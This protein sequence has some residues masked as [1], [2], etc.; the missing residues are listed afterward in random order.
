MAK[1]LCLVQ[2]PVGTRSG[3]GDHAR[4]IV[5]SLIK[6]DRY[7]VKIIPTRWG[8]TPMNALS[9]EDP[10]H[11]DI[12]DRILTE[13][14]HTQPDLFIQITVP[15]E[16][17]PI[18]KFNIGITAGIETTVPPHTWLEGSNRMNLIIVPSEFS[19]TTL[20]HAVYTK[21]DTRTKQP[22]GN[23]A[24]EKPI[25][26][27]FEGTDV[28]V[29]GNTNAQS[30]VLD[31]AMNV[32]TTPFN[33]LFVGHWL[34]GDF[35]ED[36]KN[37]GKLIT[38]FYTVF[39]NY[40]K[41]TQP[42]LILKTSQATF[43]VLDRERI[44][45]KI[46]DVQ[47]RFKGDVPPIYFI[48]GDLTKDEMASLYNHDKVHAHISFTKGEGF[49][50]PLLEASLSGKPTLVTNWSGHIDFITEPK[51]LLTGELKQVHPSA[52]DDFILKE[53]MWF[54]V[55]LTD[56][57]KRMVDVVENYK[58]YVTAAKKLSKQNK[59]QMSFD[60]MTEKLG[61]ILD[62]YAVVPENI[63]I[64]LPALSSR[65]KKRPT[66]QQKVRAHDD[67]NTKATEEADLREDIRTDD[68]GEDTSPQVLAGR[69]A[70]TST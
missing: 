11:K 26:V 47:G 65:K 44:V 60:A 5:R 35:G 70:G 63:K 16:F 61:E 42:G 1:P 28:E 54:D 13:Q 59:V 52:A 29:Y 15:N 20:A 49:G 34:Q 48:H 46:R 21:H 69:V 30:D 9:E 62:K 51:F 17:T 57:A 37:V 3:Y 68:S 45:D 31:N 24:L 25:E 56:A 22:I 33:F 10:D 12:I 66:V 67:N 32:V 40:P 53:G 64:K 23:I 6:L 41:D 50:R 2:G 39:K 27:L 55:S 7:N 18:G 19:K 38:T 43:S 36:R 8:V 14:L 58:D 4:D